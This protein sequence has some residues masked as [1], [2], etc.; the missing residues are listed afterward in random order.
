MKKH[1]IWY[2]C[3]SI[4][5]TQRQTPVDILVVSYINNNSI[6]GTTLLLEGERPLVPLLSLAGYGLL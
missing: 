4:A 3:D 2:Y 1:V 6:G 5:L